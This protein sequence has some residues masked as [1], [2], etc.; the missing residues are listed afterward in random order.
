MMSVVITGDVH[1]SIGG[2]DQAFSDCSEAAL[3]VDYAA[4]AARHG[5]KVTL[6][7]TGRAVLDD[8]DDARALWAMDNVEIGGHGWNAF[9]PRLWHGLLNRTLGSPHGPAWLQERMIRRT[10][11]TL[12]RCTGQPVRSWRNHAYRHDRQTPRLLAASNI[13][14]W[15]DELN[16]ERRH[17][18][19]HPSGLVVLPINTIPDHE[20]LRHGAWPKESAT[21]R[22]GGPAY[23]ADEWCT[24][25]CTQVD[26]VVQGGGT[27]TILAHPLCMK[28]VDNW[29]TFERLCAFLSRY[30]S[31]HA[32]Q[33]VV[34]AQ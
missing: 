10:C 8:G 31:L 7:F 17:P 29:A 1:H 26:A 15:S 33:A 5:L 27:A 34:T 19:R 12:E 32:Q 28:I 21:L 11:A 6:F 22:R 2:A 20:H 25:V 4:I 24:R 9:K 3:A 13:R 14:T 23:D 18:Y 30:P 16:P